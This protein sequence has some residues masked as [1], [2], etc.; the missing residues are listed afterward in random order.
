MSLLVMFNHLLFVNTF[1]ARSLPLTP[2]RLSFWRI[3][4]ENIAALTGQ[5][6]LH[7]KLGRGGRAGPALRAGLF[8]FKKGFWQEQVSMSGSRTGQR[9][10]QECGMMLGAEGA[11]S[12]VGLEGW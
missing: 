11:V 6:Q 2:C 12:E 8:H 4:R 10:L 9:T 3:N 5:S 7:P 1:A